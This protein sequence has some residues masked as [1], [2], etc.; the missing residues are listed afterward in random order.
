MF[1]GKGKESGKWPM[2]CS[3][4]CIR[5]HRAVSY[6]HLRVVEE[7]GAMATPM[8]EPPPQAASMAR[9]TKERN[10]TRKLIRCMADSLRNNAPRMGILIATPGPRLRK[11]LHTNSCGGKC[12]GHFTAGATDGSAQTDCTS[13]GDK[14]PPAEATGALR[15]PDTKR[16]VWDVYL[17]RRT[18]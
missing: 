9:R 3:S 11:R 8:D 5:T 2:A 4:F 10:V 15:G 14:H 1:T 18:A 7:G 17:Q 12:R 16:T 6:T 13:E